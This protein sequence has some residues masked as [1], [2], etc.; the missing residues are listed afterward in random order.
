[1]QASVFIYRYNNSCIK[2]EE[3]DC[4]MVAIIIDMSLNSGLAYTVMNESA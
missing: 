4:F 3:Y 2:N 1:M